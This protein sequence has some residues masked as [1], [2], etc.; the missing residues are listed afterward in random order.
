MEC[1]D[2]QLE[3][4]N[5]FD[6]RANSIV[7]PRINGLGFSSQGFIWQLFRSLKICPHSSQTLLTL[8]HEQILQ[9]L[10][11][12]SIV[13]SKQLLQTCLLTL[14][15]TFYNSVQA[16][17]AVYIISENKTLFC[18]SEDSVKILRYCTVGYMILI[19]LEAMINLIKKRNIQSVENNPRKSVL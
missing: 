16:T 4:I 5:I 12:Q 18:I 9:S 3:D 1:T 10:R 17:H 6:Y 14:S 7:E 13:G 19:Y 8:K 11:V 15:D 2:S